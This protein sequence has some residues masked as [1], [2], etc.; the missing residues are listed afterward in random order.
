MSIEFTDVA[1]SVTVN[2]LPFILF[3]GD[4]LDVNGTF[5]TGTGAPLSDRRL[6]V[7]I[8][9]ANTTPAVTDILGNFNVSYIVSGT[10]SLGSQTITIMQPG[11]NGMPP[12]TLYTGQ[13]TVIPYN[14]FV[15]IGGP[16]I[17]I[18]I[19]IIAV[20]MLM[21]TR[22]ESRSTEKEIIE[23]VEDL[24][25][26][27]VEPSIKKP[28]VAIKPMTRP[29]KA[30]APEPFKADVVRAPAMEEKLTTPKTQKKKPL[31]AISIDGEISS[32]SSTIKKGDLKQALAYTYVAS[33]KIALTHGFEVPDSMTHQEF[34]TSIEK[35][36][37]ALAQ[38]LQFII[39]PYEAV[40]YARQDVSSP[41]LN[42][43][44][45][46]LKEFYMGLEDK[47]EGAD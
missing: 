26:A 29:I 45:N 16:L 19:L 32:I 22:R 27:N 14:K 17:L 31:A 5:T 18:A 42:S 30:A 44:I 12:A 2:G 39:K 38:P 36:Y 47:E 37:P 6:D 25:K 8:A 40:T 11:E 10:E 33:R 3:L 15:A 43:A 46:G 34:Y 13:V 23:A 20:P 9:G 4:Q 35:A 41:D 28:T 21:R 24:K 7:A 1:R